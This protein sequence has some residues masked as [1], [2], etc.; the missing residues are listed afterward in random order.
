MYK[1][2]ILISAIAA[3]SLN[4]YTAFAQ[5][6]QPKQLHQ[7][8]PINEEDTDH[9]ERFKDQ[10]NL[11]QEQKIQIK[12]IREKRAA[13]K[14]DLKNKLKALREAERTEIDA[15]LTEEQRALLKEKKE[16]KEFKHH[17]LKG[18]RP[19]PTQKPE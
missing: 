11:T 18:K 12:A 6:H 4:G 17:E 1:K 16:A 14:A 3:L 2:T 19:V 7:V 13:E 15:V 9:V 8:N 5:A 10:L